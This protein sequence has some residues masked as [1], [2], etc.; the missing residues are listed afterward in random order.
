MKALPASLGRLILLVGVASGAG[1]ACGE[2]EAGR[3]EAPLPTD[4]DALEERLAARI[5]EAHADVERTPKRAAAWMHLGMTYEANEL[6]RLALECYAGATE[7]RETAKTWSR[8]AQAHEALGELTASVEAI[9]RS[10][11]LE[12]DYAP[13]HW[14]LGSYL[15]DLGRFDQALASFRAATRHDADYLGGWI[16]IARVLLQTGKP[17]ESVRVLEQVLS[18][19]P[20]DATARRLLKTALL[21]AGRPEDAARL[22]APWR[23]KSSPG[24]DPWHRE[25]RAYRERPLMEQ[26]LDH[27]QKGGPKRAVK[28]LEEFVAEQP[29]DL[30]ALSYLAWGYYLSNREEDA[31]RAARE[32][33]AVDPD[34]VPVLTVLARIHEGSDRSGEALDVLD[35]VLELEPNDGEALRKRGVIQER[36]GRH[37]DAI[38]SFRRLL[39]LDRRDPE[40]WLAIGRC[41]L[42]LERWAGAA[43]TFRQALRNKAPEEEALLGLAR[44]QIGLGELD[45]AQET[46]RR[47]PSLEGDGQRLLETIAS[48]RAGGEG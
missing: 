30:N 42:A 19:K 26:A 40:P 46:V 39:E 15:F 32:A 44:A 5:L 37:E 31:L 1:A 9:Q 25:F 18:R 23:Q 33:L 6:Y 12:G 22:N 36:T 13:S 16:G 8:A 11:E 17:D 34:S 43:R 35:H 3:T 45:E 14:R 48:L 20:Q 29:D 2:G 10:I 24:K 21:Q 27:L 7:R 41:E 28:L 4:L 47:L 38:R